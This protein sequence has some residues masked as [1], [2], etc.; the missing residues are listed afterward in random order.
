MSSLIT[1]QVKGRSV[2]VNAGILVSEVVT[3]LVNENAPEQKYEQ[4]PIV[5]LRVNNEILPFGARITVD[6]TIEGVPLF[7]PLGKRIYRH[8]LSYLLAYASERLYPERRLIIGHAL[9]DGFYYTYDGL[10]E[11]KREDVIALSLELRRLVNADLP[12]EMIRLSYNDALS[13][14]DKK[15]YASTSLLLSYRNDPTLHL[16]QINDFIDIAYEPLLHRSGLLQLWELRPYG[17]KGMLLRYPLSGNFLQLEPFKDNPLLFSIFEEYKRWAALL[18]VD[19]LGAMNKICGSTDIE[20]FIRMNEDLQHRKISEIADAIVRRN[21]VKVVFIA[22]P[23]SSGK[24][25]FSLRLAI[26]LRLLGYNPVKISLDNYYRPKS[27]AP[28]DS[29]GKPDLEVLEALDLELFRSNLHDLYRK[30]EVDL[31]RFDFS[32]DGKRYFDNKPVRLHDDTILVIEGIHGLNPNLAPDI[33]QSTIFKIYISALTQ[34][35]LDDHNRISTTDN[36]ILRRIVRDH[37]TRFTSAQKTLEMWPSVER[38]EMLHI[39]PYQ[40]EADLM[41]NSALDYELAVLKPYVEPLLRTV[42]PAAYEAYPVARRLLRFL[43]NVYPIPSNLVPSDSLL[44]E[45]IGGSEF[46][47]EC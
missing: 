27:Q 42:K 9:G 38:G 23:S 26:Q 15:G 6:A 31:P 40:N 11:L 39:F 35:N 45:F 36:R 16:Y 21:T 44:R 2:E 37:K 1:L 22:G 30:A 46:H 25:T 19:S 12:I 41:I 8:S 24:T 32:G 5:A 18:K 20:T 34:L 7:S 17:E 29:D 14:F 28:L 43:D 10:E 13:Y 3:S 4:N 33:D 47:P